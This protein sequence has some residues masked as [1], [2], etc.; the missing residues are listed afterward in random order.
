ARCDDAARVELGHDFARFLRRQNARHE[1]ALVLHADARF[2]RATFFLRANEKE[3]AALSEPHVDLHLARE[4]AAD[5]NALLHEPHVRLAR[6]L[7]AHA[8]AVA[9]ARAAAN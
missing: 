9:T 7:R 8:P 3:V 4:V 5:A 1:T 6:P 2:E